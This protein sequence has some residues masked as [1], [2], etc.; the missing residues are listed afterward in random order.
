M[1][2][3]LLIDDEP[4]LLDLMREALV[5]ASHE[6]TAVSDGSYVLDGTTGADFQLVVTDIIMP[7]VEGIETLVHLLKLNPKLKII[8]ISG[9]GRMG[10]SFHLWL[11]DQ[12]GAY[13][14]LSKPF[15]LEMLVNLVDQV[16]GQ[17]SRAEAPER[18]PNPPKGVRPQPAIEFG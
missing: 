16:L 7:K 12:L 4:E 3:I 2:K 15:S 6:V 9:G 13:S 10:S 11:A 14:T 5:D 17:D 1:A 18:F 8:A